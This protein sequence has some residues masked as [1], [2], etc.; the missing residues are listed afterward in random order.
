MFSFHFSKLLVASIIAAIFSLGGYVASTTSGEHAR[1]TITPQTLINTKGESVTVTLGVESETPVNVFAGVI[2]FDSTKLSV[3]KIS[4]NESAADLWA[5]KPW[6]INGEGTLHFIGGTTKPGGFTGSSPLITITFFL[7]QPGVS[8]ISLKDSRMLRHDGLGTN[9]VLATSLD[10]IVNVSSEGEIV[11]LET[12]KDITV[13][14]G[15]LGKN[16]DLS[17]DGKQSIADVSVLLGDLISNAKRSDLNDDGKV[18][19]ADLSI[20]LETI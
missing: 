3:A 10:T 15:S 14:G 6:Y 11:P 5:E 12:T 17:D 16:F 20:L 9:E 19:L 4:Y 8:Y 2:N 7:E 18:S 13:V 1:F